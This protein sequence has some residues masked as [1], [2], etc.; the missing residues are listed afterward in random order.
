MGAYEGETVN[1]QGIDGP[2]FEGIRRDY[3]L[4]ETI[5]PGETVFT[6]L[7]EY[8]ICQPDSDGWQLLPAERWPEVQYFGSE[9]YRGQWAT[10]EELRTRAGEGTFSAEHMDLLDTTLFHE[11][12]TSPATRLT[13]ASEA[14]L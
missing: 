9:H 10:A 13:I 4:I 14:E 2:S 12:I 3:T 1:L 6:A 7:G 5:R 11:R 8:E